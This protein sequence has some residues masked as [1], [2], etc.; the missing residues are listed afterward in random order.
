MLI[1]GVPLLF[2]QSYRSV[3]IFPTWKAPPLPPGSSLR[4]QAFC[5]GL[6]A[7]P[8]RAPRAPGALPAPALGP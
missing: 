3:G 2:T 7:A 4:W 8:Q 5:W 1:T 6:Q